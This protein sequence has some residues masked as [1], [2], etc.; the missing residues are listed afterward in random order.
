MVLETDNK[1][2][3]EIVALTAWGENRS[4]GVQGMQSV[5]NS[6]MNRA[7][8]PRWWG[9]NP[10][11]VCLQPQQYDCWNT[12]TANYQA[13]CNVNESDPAYEEALELA[14]EAIEG[15]LN[16]ITHGAC[17][18]YAKTMKEPPY[19]AKGVTPCADI[20]GQLFFNNIK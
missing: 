5:I 7:A 1:T 12:T 18:Y 10:R 20:A 19:W 15:T 11:D 14:R 4:G 3:I 8:H 16:D 6:I 13:M 2:E 9:N 17:F